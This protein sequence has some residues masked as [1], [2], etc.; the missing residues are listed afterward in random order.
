MDFGDLKFGL[1]IAGCVAGSIAV[2]AGVV[3]VIVTVA[4][5]A[6]GS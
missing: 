3:Y 1:F 2:I 5:F 4:K 6:W